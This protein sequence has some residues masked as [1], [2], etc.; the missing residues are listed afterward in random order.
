[1]LL[2]PRHTVSPSKLPPS[3]ICTSVSPFSWHAL[4]AFYSAKRLLVTIKPVAAMAVLLIEALLYGRGVAIC[5]E[6]D[7]EHKDSHQPL[8]RLLR[9][10]PWLV[11]EMQNSF[12]LRLKLYYVEVVIRLQHHKR[13]HSSAQC[14][15]K[16]QQSAKT[17]RRYLNSCNN[18]VAASTHGNQTDV[19][20]VY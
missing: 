5:D 7:P 16:T 20:R 19:H 11:L 4:G 3:I 13:S 6:E 8:L 12:R 1:M 18:S 9:F 17:A 15:A 10:T 14:I 2:Q